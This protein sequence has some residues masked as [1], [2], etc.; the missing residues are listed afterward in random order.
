MIVRLTNAAIRTGRHPAVLK[1]ASGEVI[2]K[3]GKDDYTKLQADRSI[4]QLSCMGKVVEEVVAEL[5]SDEAERSGR[6]SAK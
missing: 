4:S 2:W 6:L 1:W 3:P 5:L